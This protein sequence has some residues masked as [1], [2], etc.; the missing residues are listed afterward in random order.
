MSFNY[1]NDYYHNSSMSRVISLKGNTGTL[2][3]DTISQIRWHS[4][5]WQTFAVSSWDGSIR[6]YQLNND[7]SPSFSEV[8]VFF[9]GLPVLSFC[10]EFTSFN[11]MVG[12]IDGTLLHLDSSSGKTMNVAKHNFAIRDLHMLGDLLL[13]FDEIG[14]AHV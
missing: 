3:M 11:F 4:T 13:S 9:F 14:R 12:L 1:R 10:W 2:P 5:D 7:R 8:F 6:M